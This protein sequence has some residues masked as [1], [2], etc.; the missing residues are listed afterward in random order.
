MQVIWHWSFFSCRG[1]LSGGTGW[2][3]AAG[4]IG[5]LL[6]GFPCGWGK[7]NS[8]ERPR[9]GEPRKVILRPE[10]DLHITSEIPGWRHSWAR[11][12]EL[13][14]WSLVSLG[15]LH[16]FSQEF[17][18]RHHIK[19]CEGIKAE[20]SWYRK[21][22]LVCHNGPQESRGD[23]GVEQSWLLIGSFQ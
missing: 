15:W 11:F 6:P 17:E 16:P 7:L 13:G 20:K 18:P 12:P 5:G 14:S 22:G 21:R 9:A 3:R 10:D 23:K 4:R 19:K 1:M 8:G 2:E